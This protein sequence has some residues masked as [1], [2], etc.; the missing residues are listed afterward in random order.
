M[1]SIQGDQIRILHILPGGELSTIKCSLQMVSL[2]ERPIYEA[3]SYVWGNEQDLTTI[4]VSGRR[5]GITRN[6]SAALS[7]LR[8]QSDARAVWVDQLCI[9]QGDYGEKQTQVQLMRRIYTQCTSGIIWLGEV[10]KDIPMNDAAAVVEF[11]RFLHDILNAEDGRESSKPSFTKSPLGWEGFLKALRSIGRR[12]CPWW[13]RIWT[14]QEAVLPPAAM[15]FWGPFTINWQILL[16]VARSYTF[17]SF[18][19]LD[20]VYGQSYENQWAMWEIFRYIKPLADMKTQEFDALR[21][22]TRWRGRRSTDP[23]DKVYALSGL[24]RVGTLPSSDRCDYTLDAA[25]VF[26]A[27]TWDLIQRYGDLKPLSM[28][29]RVR[30]EDATPGV[31]GWAL[32][33]GPAR[34]YFSTWSTDDNIYDRSNANKGMAP[35]PITRH[36]V[37][38]LDL[39]GV[40]VDTIKVKA[41]VSAIGDGK[42]EPK[43]ANDMLQKLRLWYS[44]MVKRENLGALKQQWR[45]KFARLMLNDILRDKDWNVTSEVT[46]HSLNA[47]FDYMNT[48]V[49]NHTLD[50]IL[51]STMWRTFFITASGLMGL[52]NWELEPEDEVWIFNAGRIPFTIRKRAQAQGTA[53]EYEFLDACYVQ[54]IMQG[55]FVTGKPLHEVEKAIR[56]F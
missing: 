53:A 37:G 51:A 9:D 8:S 11:F 49:P 41:E 35:V 18:W 12:E 24:Q 45:W 28:S 31:S 34:G 29:P 33:L 15:V 20:L 47:V 52:G 5:V 27:V 4:E 26:E 21:I 54:G 23:R 40:Y 22:V 30:H 39:V 6:L 38:T 48:G 16:S 10:R 32:D 46:E 7:R 43:N 2:S 19:N 17:L 36:A 3:L 1:E 14:V 13:N 56:L 44:M 42:Y 25:Q 50:S 55:A